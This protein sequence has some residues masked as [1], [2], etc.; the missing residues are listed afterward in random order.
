MSAPPR[1]MYRAADRG[2]FRSLRNWRRYSPL[3]LWCLFVTIICIFPFLWMLKTSFTPLTEAI[4]YPPTFWPKTFTLGNYE[5]LFTTH[6]LSFPFTKFIINSV[7]ISLLATIGRVF[8]SALAGYAFARIKFKGS[9]IAFAVLISSLFMPPVMLIIPLYTTYTA[10]DFIDTHWPL[11]LPGVFAS[12]FGTFLMRQFFRT[13]PV[14]LEEAAR[15]DGANRFYTFWAIMVPLSLPALAVVAIFTFQVMWNDFYTPFIFINSPDQFT[16][17]VG[18]A[19][20]AAG[21]EYGGT[22]DYSVIMAGGMLAMLP[23][24]VVYIALQ[25]YFVEGIALTGVKG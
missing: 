8:F 5:A 13:I 14:E 20:F 11:I 24:V 25:Q 17:P 23:V 16:L 1:E 7:Y 10:I 2:S 22:P 19:S 6:S 4:T 18:L 21:I 15:I 12:T 9:G 3:Y